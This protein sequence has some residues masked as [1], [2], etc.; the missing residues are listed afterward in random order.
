[1]GETVS[2]D[3]IMEGPD[4]AARIG[5]WLGPALAAIVFALPLG[6]AINPEAHRL[7]AITVLMAT[8]WMTEAVP[9]AI[10][11]LLPL[12]LFPLFGIAKAQSVAPNYG[13]D[14]IWLFFG[15]FQLAFAVERWNLHRRLAMFM[16]RTFGTQSDRLILGFMLASGLLSMWLLNTSTT[17]MLLPVAMAVAAT[18]GKEAFGK[19]LMLGLAYAASVGGMGTYLGTAPNGVFRDVAAEKNLALGFGEWMAFAAPLS[20]I[21]IGFIWLYLTRFAFK[22]ERTP[23]AEDHPAHAALSGDRAPWS[24][25]EKRVAVIFVIAVIAWISRKYVP[26]ALGLNPKLVTDATIA[27]IITVILDL[28]RAPTPKGSSTLLSWNETAKTP[29]HI[30]ILFGGGFALAA[31]FDS[32]QLSKWMG[33]ILADLTNGWPLPLM[34]LAVVLFMTFLTEVTSNTAT[35]IILLPVIRDLAIAAEI[36]PL[37]LMLPA[38]LAAS[39]AFMLPVA[40]PPNA[41][42]YGSGLVRLPEMARVGVGINLGTGILI[43]VWTLTWGRF[44]L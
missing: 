42:V 41:V 17:L 36:D 27:I 21:L 20:V 24:A 38:T 19:A 9:V 23:L 40:T 10:T 37:M 43:T 39:C 7:A 31:A 5:L 35:S 44:V 14:L 33:S 3:E 29:W 8:W 25:G 32:T 1:M 22:V 28:F 6:E 13:K 30:L 34:V 2:E 4:R 15:G 12:A 16:V 18:I 26:R 11:A